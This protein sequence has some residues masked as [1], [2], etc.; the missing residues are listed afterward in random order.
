MSEGR[1][2]LI[3]LLMVAGESEIGLTLRE[4]NFLVEGGWVGVKGHGTDCKK[5]IP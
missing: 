2:S 3:M 1:R 5:R 4:V